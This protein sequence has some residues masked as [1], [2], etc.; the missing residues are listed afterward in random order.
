MIGQHDVLLG[1][2]T[3]G[4]AAVTSEGLY[5]HI[6]CKCNLSGKVMY[7][8]V[9]KWNNKTENLGILVPH[10]EAFAVDTKI[11]V[12][13]AGEGQ[14]CFRVIPKHEKLLENFI[15]ICAEEPFAYLSRLEN[16]YLHRTENAVGVVIREAP[17][18]SQP[19]SDQNP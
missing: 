9:V 16:A 15:P 4:Q 14:V 5:Y 2:E 12:K 10:A 17:E 13:R 18:S 11:P 1:N 19:G 3:V 6:V 8:L 7:K